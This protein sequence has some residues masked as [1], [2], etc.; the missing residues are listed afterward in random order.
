MEIRD[1]SLTSFNLMMC[2]RRGSVPRR[3][4]TSV[5]IENSRIVC[6]ANLDTEMRNG[7]YEIDKIGRSL[8]RDQMGWKHETLK[9][10]SSN[11]RMKRDIEISYSIYSWKVKN[12]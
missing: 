4:E 10:H 7:N 9:C 3:M 1:L 11:I 12:I 5:E 6:E 2:I 8:R